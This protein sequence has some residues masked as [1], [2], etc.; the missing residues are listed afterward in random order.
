MI[1]HLEAQR[2][3]ASTADGATGHLQFHVQPP[4]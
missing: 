4:S 2:G 3:V 1:C